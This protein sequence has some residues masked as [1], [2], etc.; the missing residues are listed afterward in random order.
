MRID[1]I[2][3]SIMIMDDEWERIWKCA[4]VVVSDLKLTC[5]CV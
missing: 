5:V 4:V 3:Y 2:L 1:Y